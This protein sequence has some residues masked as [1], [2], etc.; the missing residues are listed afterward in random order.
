MIAKDFV[1]IDVDQMSEL[2]DS[3]RALEEFF[4]E[5]IR[6]KASD[7]FLLAERDHVTVAIRR[8][9]LVEKLTEVEPIVGRQFINVVKIWANVDLVERRRPMDGRIELNVAGRNIDVRVS[10]LPTLFGEDATLRLLDPHGGVRSLGAL[11]LSVEE[12]NRLMGMLESPSGLIL[13]TGPTGAGKTTT[14]YAC[15][16]HLNNGS[17]KINTIEEPVEY[18][19]AGVR[20]SQV[21]RAIDVDFAQLLA[22]VLR[23]APD[24][25]MIGEIRDAETAHTAVRAANS[26]HLVFA[27][28][29]APVAAGAVESMFALGA[30]PHFLASSLVGVVAQRLVRRLCRRCRVK[31]ELPDAGA[32]FASVSS[33]VDT[34]GACAIYGPRGCHECD[35]T[36]YDGRCGVYEILTAGKHV[37]QLIAERRPRDEIHQAAVD[38]GMI[39]F[40]RASLVALAN[41]ATSIEEVTRC[42]PSQVLELES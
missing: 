4:C 18:S 28:L 33:L 9:G 10:T 8:W 6:R 20:Q 7:L 35:D 41:G 12:R 31:Y 32:M 26:G 29:H 3:S 27:T 17:R 42:I 14:L 40:R 25:V 5:A 19:I 38:A 34:D 23:Q 11:G 30:T 24:V 37:R 13:V 21:N 22:S 36:G 16:S 15:L 2:A 39:S 1:A